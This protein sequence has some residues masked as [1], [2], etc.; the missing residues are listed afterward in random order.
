LHIIINSNIVNLEVGLVHNN[1]W[2][3]YTFDDVLRS[4]FII[5][6]KR[7]YAMR[8]GWYVLLSVCKQIPANN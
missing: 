8:S 3:P 1:R 6:Y 2:H 7:S 5:P 4:I